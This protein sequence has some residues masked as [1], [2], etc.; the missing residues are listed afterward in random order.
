MAFVSVVLKRDQLSSTAKFW[1]AEVRKVSAELDMDFFKPS[2]STL[3]WSKIL[4][5][6][7]NDL[8]L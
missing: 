2:K 6:G 1:G 5:G 4:C 3:L 8:E 7:L